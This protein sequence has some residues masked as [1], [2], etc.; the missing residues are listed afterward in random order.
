MK[1]DVTFWLIIGL[2]PNVGLSNSLSER[3][4]QQVK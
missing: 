3:Q 2:T 4:I 1:N